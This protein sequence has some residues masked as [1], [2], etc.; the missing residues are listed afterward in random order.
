MRITWSVPVPG[1]PLDSGRGDLVR[2]RSL[3]DALA[4]LGHEVRAVAA[5]ERVGA[6][7]GVGAYRSSLRELLPGQVA[8]GLRTLGRLALARSHARRVG[9]EARQHG[10]DLIVE[11]QVHGM[12]S[13]AYAARRAGIPLVLDD[14]SPPQEEEALLGGFGSGEIRRFLGQAGAAKILLVSSQA[15]ARRLEF[16]GIPHGKLGVVPNGVDVPHATP[17]ARENAREELGVMGQCVV[18]YAGSFQPWHRLDLLVRAVADLGAKA[19]IHLLLMG[20]GAERETVLEETSRLGIQDRTT[21]TGMVPLS[22]LRLILRAAD[23]GV[24]PGSN[25]YGQPMKL[26]EYGAAGLP[27][28][29]PDLAPV[30]EVLEHR[31]TGLLFR[32]DDADALR[33]VLGALVRAPKL[34]TELGEAALRSAMDRS[35]QE[36]ARIMAEF[37]DYASRPGEEP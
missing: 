24:L 28:V 26:L 18:A 36:S 14:C 29:A 5:S 4:G 21:F 15:L 30:R 20:D 11:T 7:A 31:T 35:W 12:P 17:G 9:A 23:V 34:R 8:R 33:E 27:A 2:V 1:E 10:V 19:P 13:G 25:D 32:P 16:E 3:M 6:R 37:L 22:R